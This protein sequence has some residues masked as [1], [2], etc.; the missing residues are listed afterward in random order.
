MGKGRT[1]D[2]LY[3]GYNVYPS[4]KVRRDKDF[5]AFGWLGRWSK[6]NSNVDRYLKRAASKAR[7]RAEKKDPE[8]A[9]KHCLGGYG[10]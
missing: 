5:S 6:H 2:R 4:R 7:R 3:R 10:W 8:N 9:P 1:V